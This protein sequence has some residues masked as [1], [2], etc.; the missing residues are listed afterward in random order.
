M[1]IQRIGDITCELGE[2]PVWDAEEQA[3]YFVDILGK[4]IGRYDYAADAFATWSTKATVGSLALRK[5]GGAIV[6]F[7]DGFGLFDF[8]S[9]DVTMLGDPEAHLPSTV[10]SDGKVDPRGRFLAGTVAIDQKSM[11]CGLYSVDQGR[12]T[13]LD[14]GF[15]IT[16]GPCWSPDG[17]TFYYADC[18][19]CDI[20]AYDYDIETGA[21]ANRRVFANTRHLGG[22]PDG[23]TVDTEGRLWSAI[24]MAGKI[25]CWLPD[26]TLDRVIEVPP[27]FVS[28]VMFGGPK[29]DRLF[30]TSIYGPTLGFEAD[31]VGGQ[32]FVIDGLGATGLPEPRYAG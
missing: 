12:I 3:L 2:G 20:Y 15:G 17:R 22:I 7:G 10:W 30:V 24:C 1:K 29:L 28:S 13:K 11:I 4:K 27:K 16:N 18:V 31:V 6:A 25:A 8:G 21:I 23:A 9:G 32:L 26:G 19:P 5:E 14:D